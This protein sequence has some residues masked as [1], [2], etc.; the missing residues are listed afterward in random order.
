MEGV[1]DMQE[2]DAA[3]KKSVPAARPKIYIVFPSS[4][5]NTQEDPTEGHGKAGEEKPED[6]EK[7]R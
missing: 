6:D 4:E 1:S 3:A 7:E 2:Q 5:E